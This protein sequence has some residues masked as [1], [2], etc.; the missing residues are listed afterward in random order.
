MTYGGAA[1]IASTVVAIVAGS[2]IYDKYV[3]N[4]TQTAMVY[5]D[6]TSPVSDPWGY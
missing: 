4:R 1:G 2:F 6:T 3:R 5:G